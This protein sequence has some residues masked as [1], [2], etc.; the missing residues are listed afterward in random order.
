MGIE[1]TVNIHVP[2]IGFYLKEYIMSAKR[3]GMFFVFGGVLLALALLW[4]APAYV[5]KWGIESYGSEALGTRVEV[6]SVTFSWLDTEL[7]IAGLQV[8]NPDAQSQNLV[9]VDHL[10]TEFDLG[11]LLGKKVYLE[12]LLVDGVA[13]DTTGFN[14]DD[15]ST[16]NELKSKS[17]PLLDMDLVDTDQLVAKEKAIY[18]QR[19]KAYQQDLKAK[20]DRLQKGY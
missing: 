8:A 16:N 20:Q 5:I 19:V 10:A 9:T 6:D 18:R 13:I 7:A 4:V 17:L 15:S 3:K 11:Q 12:T 2:A 1:I 14:S